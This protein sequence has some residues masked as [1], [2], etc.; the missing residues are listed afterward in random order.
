MELEH[1][2]VASLWGG[3]SGAA[4]GRQ[5]LGAITAEQT[6]FIEA[7]RAAKRFSG[8]EVIFQLQRSMNAVAVLAPKELVAML[9]TLDGVVA[10]YS[11]PWATPNNADAAPYLGVQAVWAALGAQLHGEGIRVGII[12]TGIDYL[13]TDFGGSASVASYQANDPSVIGDVAGFPGEK[14]V[15]GYDLA[16]AEYGAAHY[17]PAPDPDPF[18]YQLHG[19][20]VAGT[21]AGYGV[22]TDGST[23]RGAYDASVD[24]RAM[25][26][27]PGM[28][29]QASLYAIKVFGDYAGGTLLTDAGIEWALDPNQ[30]GDLSDHLDL[31]NISIGSPY[32]MGEGSTSTFEV[33]RRATEVGLLAVMSAGNSGDYYFIHGNMS[34]APH[35]MAVAAAWHD[36]VKYQQMTLTEPLS[37]AGGIEGIWSNFS[38]P[39][40]TAISAPVFVLG[41]TDPVEDPAAL[42]AEVAGSIVLTLR[43]NGQYAGPFAKV[44]EAAGGARGCFLSEQ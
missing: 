25:R 4:K 44:A 16:G 40:T 2:S 7:L 23:W 19:T 14:V 28:A 43:K 9:R 29:P 24:T 17:V 15:G 18:D 37:I 22:D 5:A 11:I 1:P 38:A 30:D 39:I 21:V 36:G 41:G 6:A 12:D 3:A 10:S 20:H 32:G 13:H 8:V 42:P 26:V 34:S 33:L 27:G 31:V 35:A